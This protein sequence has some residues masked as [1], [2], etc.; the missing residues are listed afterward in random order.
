MLSNNSLALVW[1]KRSSLKLVNQ[2]TAWR[3]NKLRQSLNSAFHMVLTSKNRKRTINFLKF[4]SKSLRWKCIKHV[5]DFRLIGEN[6]RMKTN[7][8][9]VFTI[10]SAESFEKRTTST[11]QMKDK[12]YEVRDACNPNKLSYCICIVAR[13]FIELNAG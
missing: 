5:H 12:T 11:S 13:D 9:F 1:S 7:E 6:K 10:K 2:G 4:R 8:Y 3:K